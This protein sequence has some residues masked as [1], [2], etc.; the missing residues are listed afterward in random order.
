MY[1]FEWETMYVIPMRIVPLAW[2]IW[3]FDLIRDEHAK[4]EHWAVF[5]LATMVD[6]PYSIRNVH[7]T[8]E[9]WAVYF[10]ADYRSVDNAEKAV[11]QS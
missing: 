3:A 11:E 2:L 4:F 9:Y 5:S 10:G 1:L 6:W 7:T 8:F